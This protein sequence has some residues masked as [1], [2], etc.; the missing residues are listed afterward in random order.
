MLEP[1]CPV[2]GLTTLRRNRQ[3]LNDASDFAVDEIEVEYTEPNAPNRRFLNDSVAVRRL[4]SEGQRGLE[5][6]MVAPSQASLLPLVVGDLSL[7]LRRRLRMKAVAHLKSSWT[8]LS[9]SSPETIWI[10]P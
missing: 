6:G 10:L 3:H 8:C 7:V 9:S 5:L 4:Q 1:R 2:V